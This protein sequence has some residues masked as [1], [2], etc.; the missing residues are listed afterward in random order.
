MDYRVLPCLYAEPK[1]PMAKP[2]RE[3]QRRQLHLG[4]RDYKPGLRIA[5]AGLE[6]RIPARKSKPPFTS[7]QIRRAPSI[8]VTGMLHALGPLCLG[9]VE[10]K[11]RAKFFSWDHQVHGHID[12]RI[13]LPERR[14]TSF[15]QPRGGRGSHIK[16]VM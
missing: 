13:L 14:A 10:P 5:L 16:H 6:P 8:A 15:A 9:Q 3:Q 4:L 7:T 12:E 2:P 11:S 1:N